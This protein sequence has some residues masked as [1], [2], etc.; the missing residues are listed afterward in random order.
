MPQLAL[1]L[2]LCLQL[3]PLH[4]ICCLLLLLRVM[5]CQQL[6]RPQCLQS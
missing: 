5:H 1:A 4:N 6:S 3:K 2:Y